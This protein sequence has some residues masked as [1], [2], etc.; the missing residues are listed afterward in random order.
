MWVGKGVGALLFASFFC[1]PK[2]AL[3]KTLFKRYT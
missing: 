3:K 2:T 1:S